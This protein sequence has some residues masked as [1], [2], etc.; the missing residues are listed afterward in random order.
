MLVCG[1]IINY[2]I[3]S[4]Q[5]IL[6]REWQTYVQQKLYDFGK[7]VDKT[8]SFVS[9]SCDHFVA[10]YS[11]TIYYNK[12]SKNAMDTEIEK[13]IEL[14]HRKFKYLK[15][16]V[17]TKSGTQMKGKNLV[18]YTMPFPESDGIKNKSV[19]NL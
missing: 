10:D 11:C 12:N 3:R 14:F 9:V 15:E 2:E 6:S 1:V 19:Q 16:E 18:V 17:K 4:N 7:S 8:H 5:P 13:I